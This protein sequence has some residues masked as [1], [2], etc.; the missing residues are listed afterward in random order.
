MEFKITSTNARRPGKA[1]FTLVE[2]L[3]TSGLAGLAMAVFLSLT[4]FTT[5]S[6]ASMTNSVDLNAR[7]RHAIDRMSKKLRQTSSVKSLSANSVSVIYNGIPLTYTYQSNRKTLVETEGSKITTLLR[8]CDDLTFSFYKRNPVTNSFNQF[9]ILTAIAETK[10]IE[11]RW[12]CSVTL[13]GNTAGSAD[14]VTAKIVLR[15][16]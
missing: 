15:S 3:V 1:G 13:L 6:I 12:R 16:K 14:I 8:N 2:V 5:R 7:S 4:L 11:V 10:V 9:P